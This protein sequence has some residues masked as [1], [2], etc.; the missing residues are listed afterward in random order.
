[1][2]PFYW[3]RKLLFIFIHM[4]SS[5]FGSLTL[6]YW[7]FMVGFISCVFYSFSCRRLHEHMLWNISNN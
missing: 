1:M 7:G 5:S 6:P 3:V 2:T 4:T